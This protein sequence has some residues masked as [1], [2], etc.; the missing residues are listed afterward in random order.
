MISI[1]IQGK[2]FKITVIPTTDNE[3]AEVD[4][5]Y[6]N[7][8]Q[9]LKLAPKM[10]PIGDWDGKVVCQEKLTQFPIA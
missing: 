5:F 4:R 9:I 3:K 8:Q 1:H 2:L 10:M 6:E 7:I